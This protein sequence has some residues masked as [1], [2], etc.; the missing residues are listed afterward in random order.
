MQLRMSAKCQKRTFV[1]ECI[2]RL[3]GPFDARV[4]FV[5][6]YFVINGFGQKIDELANQ[7]TVIFNHRAG[8]FG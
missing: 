3:C 4:D 1:L 6:K 5:A 2:I 8:E 7:N